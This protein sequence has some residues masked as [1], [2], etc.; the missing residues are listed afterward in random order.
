[1][2]SVEGCKKIL[3]A[4]GKCNSHYRKE[5]RL[6]RRGKSSHRWGYRSSYHSQ[7]VHLRKKRGSASEYPCDA[8]GEQAHEWAFI[9]KWCPADELEIQIING[10][11]IKYSQNID[12][13]VPM[14]KQ[15]HKTLDSYLRHFNAVKKYV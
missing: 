13:Y 3:Y 5:W 11:E 4:K 14:C 9:E 1:M 8:C 15:H 6:K 7:H 12:Y 10:N 2:C